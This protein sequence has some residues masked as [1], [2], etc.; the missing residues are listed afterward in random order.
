MALAGEL[1]DRVAVER[2]INGM[3]R[4]FVAVLAATAVT[5]GCREVVAPPLPAGSEQFVPPPAY[6]LWWQMVESCSARTAPFESVSWYVIPGATQ[7]SA[8]EP[9]LQG[10]WFSGGNRIVLAGRFQL[11]GQ[12]VRHEMLHALLGAHAS[13]HPRDEFLGRCA[14]VVVCE[15][16]CLRDAG[17]APAPPEGTPIVPPDSLE[18]GAEITP[19]APSASAEGGH[20]ALTLT[21]RNPTNHAVIVLLPSRSPFIR[22]VTFSYVLH[23]EGLSVQNNVRVLDASETLFAPGEIKRQAFDFHV[24]D[25]AATGGL[26]VGD[27]F[28]VGAFG[29]HEMAIPFAFLISP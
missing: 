7:L 24:G 20:F 14:G 21:A 2:M 3:A 9:D 16:Q 10:E 4:A 29:S 22:P 27:V 5:V 6:R 15:G 1:L 12:L 26:P 28:V 17:A 11:D 19:A 25:D 8:T 23:V 18:I 13:N